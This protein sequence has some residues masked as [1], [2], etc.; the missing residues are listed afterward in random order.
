[1]QK[2]S[3]AQFFEDVL[4]LS[5][6]QL[7][8]QTFSTLLT[9]NS[10]ETLKIKTPI[11]R[12]IGYAFS[13]SF[14]GKIDDLPNV[15]FTLLVN[16]KEVNTDLPATAFSL[17]QTVGIIGS[18]ISSGASRIAKT[19][20]IIPEGA[21][22]TIRTNTG[23]IFSPVHMILDGYFTDKFMPYDVPITYKQYFQLSLNAGV[24]G[25]ENF[26]IPTAR[27]R[28]VGL[29][30]LTNSASELIDNP[31]SGTNLSI[32][33]ILLLD[34]YNPSKYFNSSNQLYTNN[35]IVNIR[36]GSILNISMDNQN[37]N[38][39]NVGCTLYFSEKLEKE[40]KSGT[41]VSK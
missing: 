16:G 39:V 25:S 22:V 14:T 32:N 37:G 34:N 7:L 12:G 35:W 40:V 8:Q 38:Q 10:I 6:D 41:M 2:E 19:E 23:A 26:T 20:Y 1:M 24:S 13:V 28:I 15:F 31:L 33:G 5:Q 29:S 21:I 27:G 30:V 18:A 17:Y 9:A 3:E 11:G 36:G 4:S